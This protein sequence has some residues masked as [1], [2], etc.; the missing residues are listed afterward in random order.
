MRFLAITF[1]FTVLG[2]GVFPANAEPGDTSCVT[3]ESPKGGAVIRSETCTLSVK[4][5]EKVA[6]VNFSAQYGLPQKSSDTVA[7][8]VRI[9]HA[10]FK[11]FWNMKDV[12]NQLLKGMSVF[13]DVVFKDGGRQ[14]LQQKGVFAVHRQIPSVRAS[15]PFSINH[16]AELFT[17][18]ISIGHSSVSVHA[19]A[20][21]NDKSVRFFIRAATAL[22]Y[23]SNPAVKLS[24]CGVDICLDPFLDKKPYPSERALILSFPLG[25]Q[26]YATRYEPVFGNG[27]AFDLVT[28]R[29]DNPCNAII[30]KEDFKG[31]GIDVTVPKQLFGAVLPDS[32]GCAIIIKVPTDEGQTAAVSWIEAPHQHDYCPILWPRIVLLP[33]P[34]LARTWVLGALS[35]LAGLLLCIGSGLVFGRFTRR[36]TAVEKFEQSEEEKNVCNTVFQFIEKNITQKEISLPWVAEKLALPARKIESLVKKYHQKPFRDFLMSLRIEIAKER[37]R[38]SHSSETAIAESCGFK[39]VNEM[40]K[41]FSRFCRTTPFKFRKENQVT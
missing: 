28:K 1:F 17:K 18:T 5:C 11:Y 6:S 23:V 22:F 36:S 25:G 15:I 21:F 26:Q 24:E 20:C 38:S 33:K 32:F 35:F 39:N 29:I 8:L 3:L 12:P 19:T 10:P 13:T 31:F 40:E 2:Q 41:Y 16:G 9:T 34:L 4:A 37:L 27:G 7:F 30:K 14:A